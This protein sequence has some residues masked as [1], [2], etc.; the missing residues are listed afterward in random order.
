MEHRRAYVLVN[1]RTTGNAPETTQALYARPQE[2]GPLP[3]G[4]GCIESFAWVAFSVSIC[5]LSYHP[6]YQP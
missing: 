3:W 6:T 1:N 4:L 2:V 5:R